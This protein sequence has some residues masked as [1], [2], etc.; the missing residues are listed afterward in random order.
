MTALV[1]NIW[2]IFNAV[3]IV[4]WQIIIFLRKGSW[5]ALPLSSI[6]N[7]L[8]CNRGA[9]YAT[10]SAGEIERSQLANVVGGL[11]FQQVQKYEKGTN[12]IGASRL[13][14]V[15]RILQVPIAYFFDG[16]PG[17]QKAKGNLPSSNYV[18]DFLA[19]TD[20]LSL[21]KAYTKIK[22]AKIRHHV[23]KLVDEIAGG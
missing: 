14:Y 12:R 8:E 10:A 1:A 11:T 3:L 6:F 13:H 21:A 17:Q 20:G 2:T 4:G 23:V 19:A 7:K 22:H 16:T 9:I 5:P 15:S 18:S